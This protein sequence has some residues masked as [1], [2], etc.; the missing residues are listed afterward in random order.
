MATSLPALAAAAAGTASCRRPSAFAG[1]PA[2]GPQQAAA[3]SS[4]AA[5]LLADVCERTARGVAYRFEFD[6]WGN[7]LCAATVTAP[8]AAAQAGAKQ[9]RCEYGFSPFSAVEAKER[10][11]RNALESL[12]SGSKTPESAYSSANW[13]LP[14]KVSGL[15]A[16]PPP[17]PAGGTHPSAPPQPAPLPQGQPVFSDLGIPAT[18]LRYHTGVSPS[19][20]ASVAALAPDVTPTGIPAHSA[21][22]SARQAA[23]DPPPSG[24]PG[25]AAAENPA[26]RSDRRSKQGSGQPENEVKRAEAGDRADRSVRAREQNDL[27][28]VDQIGIWN[29]GRLLPE[30][31]EGGLYS[32][33]S[34]GNGVERSDSLFVLDGA[35]DPSIA[36][37]TRTIYD[38]TESEVPP[39]EAEAREI[40]EVGDTVDWDFAAKADSR[41]RL[42]LPGAGNSPIPGL[43]HSEGNA[44][45]PTTKFIPVSTPVPGPTV[46]GPKRS[47]K[48][49]KSAVDFAGDPTRY[50]AAYRRG[51]ER[52]S[53]QPSGK[54]AF[55]SSRANGHSLPS[56]SWDTV[57]A[58]S[59]PRTGSTPQLY[60]NAS[61][62]PPRKFS[63]PEP[64]PERANVDHREVHYPPVAQPMIDVRR[65]QSRSESA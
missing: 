5:H 57:A 31:E 22:P 6:E 23:F 9:R 35:G 52:R 20:T 62:N 7:F 29:S 10:A 11:A 17:S 58:G 21:P 65:L 36:D 61:L 48:K 42:L 18:P 59:S 60:A 50:E 25:P 19:G 15:P 12:R 45:P 54:D 37:T 64:Q 32:P 2:P 24:S 33:S 47:A 4:P 49:R 55:L 43:I 44:P 27:D 34:A 41:T 51:A 46:G 38:L 8:G 53:A 63:R 1:S 56:Y 16:S 26:A 3:S 40:W 39:T 30:S 28:T 13:P 14:P